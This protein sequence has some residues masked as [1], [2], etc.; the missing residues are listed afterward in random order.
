MRVHLQLRLDVSPWVDRVILGR[1]L[2]ASI[3]VPLHPHS[4]PEGWVCLVEGSELVEKDL[5]CWD[6][7][8]CKT[9]T[10]DIN[11]LLFLAGRIM[12]AKE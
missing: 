12:S 9:Q 6:V 3:A 7:R 10:I 2:N 5:E 11:V 1:C 8:L 4:P